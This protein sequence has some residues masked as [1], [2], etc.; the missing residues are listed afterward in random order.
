MA[1]LPDLPTEILRDK[2]L[3]CIPTEEL[4]WNVGLVCRRLLFIVFDITRD[5]NLTIR[6]GQ[7]YTQLQMHKDK[8]KFKSIFQYREVV[9]SITSLHIDYPF[10]K[11]IQLSLFVNR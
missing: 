1:N 7:G 9:D 5:I 4:F 6:G 2:I 8:N 10:S 11:E 3:S